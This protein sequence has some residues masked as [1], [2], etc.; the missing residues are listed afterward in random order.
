MS[1]KTIDD[2]VVEMRFDN[3]QFER[4]VQTSLSTLDKLKRALHLDGAGKEFEKL[5]KASKNC[6]M[7]GLSKGIETV[8]AKFSALE[9]I[10]VT[11]LANITN[12]A[13]NAGTQLV[14]SLSI[15]QVAAGWDKYG[16]KTASVQ[17]IMNATG[18]SINEVNG[19][20]DKLMWFSDETS[21]G[22]TDMTQ[23]LGQLTSAGGDIDR[24]IPMITGIA[25]ATAF[26]GKGA[27]E[28]SRSIYNLNQS[29]SAGSLQYM[30]WKSLELAGIASEQL[31]RTFI[32]TGI[33]L[34][35]IKEGEVTIANF[36]TTLKDKWADTSVMEAAFG[37]F[38][39]MTEKAYEMVQAGVV[40]TAS[41]AYAILSEQ[42]DGV[43]IKA[44]KA[45]QE[46]KTFAEAIDAT[47]DAV[48]SGWMKSFELIFGNYEEA[49][50]LW[51]D[52]ANSLWDV[53]ASG[54]EARNEMLTGA[55]N[56]GW[57]Q[58][59]KEGVID[60]VDFKEAIVDTALQHEIAMKKI[61]ENSKSFEDSLESGWL[62]ADV[63]S[64]SLTALTQKTAW[65]SDEEL[66]NLGYTREQVDALENL[67]QSV[68]DGT[69]DLDEYAK[70]IGRLSGRENL[71]QAFW[72]T[73]NA[74]FADTE[75][76]VG[77]LTVLK[78]AFRD[79][80]PAMSSEQLY[81]FTEGLRKLTEKFKM[82][83]ETADKLKRSF[84]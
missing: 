10:G 44:A 9:V 51:T 3:Q 55:M 46:A 1:S 8:Q 79:I 20:L 32:E 7:S 61:I 48:S 11:A 81:A 63:L 49:K 34:G 84:E 43:Y 22:F 2:K 37:K 75:E 13:I 72:N 4:N 5:E 33:A 21:Y 56:S 66:A 27:A 18:K 15:D 38:G 52:L 82:S 59:R 23:A 80:F 47:K 28:F 30:D 12:S 35:K 26:A 83:G 70:Q 77:V 39:E 40:E 16:Q 57:S 25:N 68:Q 78:Q 65:L 19:Y 60:A 45:A 76:Q 74:F 50:I 29:Y 41:D 14:K 58:F 71:V 53:F 24:L 69:V 73:W 31:K 6:N 42:Y 64:E 36:G 62:T 54:G 17:T 67:N